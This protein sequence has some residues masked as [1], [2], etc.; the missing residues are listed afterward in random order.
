MKIKINKGKAKGFVEAPPS[1][2]MAHRLLICA[3][4]SDGI[5]EIKGITESQD[6]LATLDCL[7]ALGAQWERVPAREQEDGD[8]QSVLKIKGT[9]VR[10]RTAPVSLNCRESG[11]TLRFFVP[12]CLASEAEA[13]L[14]GSERLMERPME[15]YEE[16]CRQ[17]G[18]G[19]VQERGKLVVR[20][21]LK[22]GTFKAAGNISSQFI[23]GL[24]FAM[25]LLEGD[26][27]LEI[28][29]PV[30]S[31]SYIEMTLSAL[32]TFGIEW[33]RPDENTILISGGQRYCPQ[34]A[35]VEGDYS[36]AA[37]FQ[38]LDMLG[39]DVQVGNLD[40]DSLQ[41]DRVCEEMLKLLESG[42]PQ[43]DISDCPDLGPVLFAAAAA[44]GRGA[45]FTGTKRLKIKES[46]RGEAMARVLD[47]F[48]VGVIMEENR[49][50]IGGGGIKTPK[51][52]LY[53]FNDHR[54]VMAEAVLLSLTG[55][56]IEGAEAVSKS[57]P[58]FFEKLASLGIEVEKIE[59]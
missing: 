3:G 17:H 1:K 18:L 46:D 15:V 40:A 57:F 58:D 59:D 6:I 8:V 44:T 48:G 16:L 10:N 34:R 52:P 36:N 7:R 5:S 23:S 22:A 2:S 45:V 30:E 50:V 47:K 20:G 41:G 14:Y 55:G 51:E 56:I 54:I 9:D 42:R 31:R 4:L 35:K 39:G 24:L 28:I 37:F 53:G 49:M 26:S 21:P 11:S 25:P 38:A 43:L 19:F 13:E 32:K 33:T 12:L 29:P 27:R